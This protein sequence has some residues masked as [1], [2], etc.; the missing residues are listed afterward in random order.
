MKSHQGSDRARL[1]ASWNSSS[2]TQYAASLVSRWKSATAL[3]DAERTL[4]ID[5]VD[6]DN[7]QG[8]AKANWTSIL[9]TRKGEPVG[10]DSR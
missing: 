9:T 3:G 5:D 6:V 8:R 7:S 10:Q 2:S 1:S 4:M